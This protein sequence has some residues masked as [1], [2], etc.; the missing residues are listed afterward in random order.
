MTALA[1][2]ALDAPQAF[3]QATLTTG[4]AGSAGTGWTPSDTNAA[5]GPN[6]I[7]QVVN[8]NIIIF[9]KVGTQISVQSLP[10]FFGV[11][12]STGDPHVI[13]NEI[14]GRFA[15]EE[16]GTLNS[17]GTGTAL[18]AVSDSSDPTGTW[19]KTTINV[20]GFWDGY[21]ASGI[22]YNADAYVVHVN[23]FNN[24]FAVIPTANNANL[25]YTLYTAPGGDRVGR[26]A[27]MPGS[28][29]G[30]PFYFV[31]A[32]SDG[33]N[34][35]GGTLGTLEILKVSNIAGTPTYTDYQV[36][37]NSQEASAIHT[38]WRN[39]QLAVIGTV[40]G[41]AVV[42]WYLLN[43]SSGTPTLTQYGNILAPDGGSVFDP[44]IAIAP[45]GDIGM[46]YIS[47]ANSAMTTFITGRTTNDAPNTARGSIQV[48]TGPQSD[49]RFGD[50]HSCVVDINSSGVAQNTFWE[51]SEYMNTSGQFDWRSRIQNFSMGSLLN[52]GFESPSIANFQYSPSGGSWTF[53]GASPS[54]SGIVHNGSGF[55]NPN[56]PEGAQAAFVQEFGAMS[57]S[58]SG[59]SPGQTYTITFSACQRSGVNQH[60][61]QSWNVK[62]DNNVVGSYNPGPGATSYVDYSCTFTA[63]AS[64]H[65]LTFAGTDLV[66]GDNTV[67]IDNVR[68]TVASMPPPNSSFE[69]PGIA[70]NSYV[71]NPGGG[72]WTFSGSPGNGSG[73]I[74]NGT[75]AWGSPV[76][77]AGRQIAFVQANG[78]I[79]QS[80]SGFTA[81]ASYLMTFSACQRSGNSQSWNVTVNGSVVGSYNPGSG[82]SSFSD[83]TAT[84]VAPASSFTLAFVGT[85]LAGGDNTIFLDN[86]RIQ[87]VPPA[88]AN[89]GFETPSIAS[90]QYNPGGG[91]WTFSGASPNGSGIVHN[92]SG[93]SN[94]NAPEGVQA[95]F[96]QELGTISQ[97]IPGFVPGR[98]YTITFAGCQRP[99]GNQHGGESWNV[100]I[101]STVIGSYNPGPAATSYVDYSATFTA[102]AATHTLTFAGTNLV[103]GDNTVFIDNVR[104]TAVAAPSG[105]D[106]DSG[107]PYLPPPFLAINIGVNGPAGDANYDVTAQAFQ[108]NEAGD[109]VDGPADSFNFVYQPADEKCAITVHLTALDN[110][111]P[112]AEGGIVVRESL[113]PD[114]REASLWVNLNGDLQFKYRSTTGGATAAARLAGVM[115]GSGW[116]KLTRYGNEFRGEYSI[117]GARWQ[118]FGQSTVRMSRSTYIGLGTSAGL[119]PNPAAGQDAA[120][121]FDN[122]N[123]HP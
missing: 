16:I 5:V 85:N 93:F 14:T 73:L 122:V 29:S 34:W 68:I 100:Q 97:S 32:N 44:A 1:L 109:G 110:D 111:Y 103:G 46:E 62:I 13:Y 21:G 12:S 17:S 74:A 60:G 115:P 35:T 51:C 37:A 47:V 66:G 106:D 79:S 99:G 4:F 63:T 67:F 54:G 71:Y 98:T 83:Y 112:D 25:N 31:E 52:S 53:S 64:T 119:V 102:T 113:D 33:A 116:L 78:S 76:A 7:V 39:N 89:L 41:S 38:T 95:A 120:G 24:Q 114:A 10:T 58:V 42:Q 123:V 105:E 101:D 90:Y 84:F 86:I 36:S 94:P 75:S 26:P 81:G 108:V 57:Q 8:N 27:C 2:T 30:G 70:N 118:P 45:N 92:G 61:G 104:I 20:P 18:F 69:A 80:L 28:T 96:V 49:G 121:H 59:F 91:S 15:V 77:P 107:P 56:A 43:T 55:S 22:G 48:V 19:H 11:G 3:G 65:T 82:A 9:N 87:L 72:S 40:G 23:G 6:H 117:D 88:P 50:Y